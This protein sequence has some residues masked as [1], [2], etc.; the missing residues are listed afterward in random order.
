MI[1][2]R[3]ENLDIYHNLNENIYLGLKFLFEAKPDIENGEY[4]I[5]NKTKAIVDEYNTMK[6]FPHGFEAHKHVIDIQYP[7]RGLER[8]K[9]SPITHMKA[10]SEYDAEHD[11][12]YFDKPSSQS[13]NVDIGNGVFAIFFPKDGHAPQHYINEPEY[14]KKITIKVSL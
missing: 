7:I 4:I 9:W 3:L 1:V 6:S 5:N 12:T 2:D 8:I 10:I 13:T 14:I 11:R